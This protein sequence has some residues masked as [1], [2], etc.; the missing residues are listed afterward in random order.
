[1]S[2]VENPAVEPVEPIENPTP[3][4]DSTAELQQEPAEPAEQPEA[5]PE[6]TFSQEELDKIVQKRLAK[7]SRR[8]ARMA[9]IEAEN[10]FLKQQMEAAKPQPQQPQGKPSVDQFDT[11]EDYLDALSDWKVEQK[12]SGFQQQTQRQSEDIQR[13]RHAQE[14][15]AR[16]QAKIAEGVAKYPDFNDVVSDN[17][18]LAITPVMA[19]AMLESEVF[20]DIAYY[21]GDNP[22]EAARISRLPPVSQ[23]RE[24]VKLES[25]VNTPPK[26]TKAPPPIVPSGQKAQAKKDPA[27]FTDREWAEWVRKA[28]K[29]L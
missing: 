8:V 12:L 1:M 7:E 24:I 10:R 22:E 16:K 27:E 14:F 17:P 2:E 18:S 3:V 21:L 20:A 19:E 13:Q 5:K 26:P 9:E 29:G 28:R 23:A 15:E 25:K 6:K 4:D 11:Y